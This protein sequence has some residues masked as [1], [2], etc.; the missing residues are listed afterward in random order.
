MSLPF[1]AVAEEMGKAGGACDPSG[2]G[3]DELKAAVGDGG[4][5]QIIPSSSSTV[6]NLTT[7]SLSGVASRGSCG[8]TVSDVSELVITG[9]VSSTTGGGSY[10]PPSSTS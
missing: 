1:G 5:V 9:L 6:S 8:M 4:E 3:D 10:A 2:A 7:F